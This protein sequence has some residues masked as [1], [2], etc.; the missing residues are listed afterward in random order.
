M[1]IL[2]NKHEEGTMRYRLDKHRVFILSGY[3][4][5]LSMLIIILATIIMAYL[6]DMELLIT[7]NEYSEAYIELIAVPIALIVSSIGLYYL[8]K[9]WRVKVAA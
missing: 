3:L 1:N 8:I 5:G 2:R 4:L 9:G 7:I 6:N